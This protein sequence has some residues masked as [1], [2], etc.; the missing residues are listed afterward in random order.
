[1]NDYRGYLQ[2]QPDTTKM[3]TITCPLC[4]GALTSRTIRQIAPCELCNGSGL[5][6]ISPRGALFPMPDMPG[7]S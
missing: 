1:M 2:Q 7:Q 5:A 6:K 4:S 3:Q